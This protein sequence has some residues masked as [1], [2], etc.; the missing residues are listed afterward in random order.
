MCAALA[1]LAVS[2]ATRAQPAP[3][4]A[5][6][7]FV[8]DP[9]Q[10]DEGYFASDMSL[11][12]DGDMA[13]I[14]EIFGDGVDPFNP[15]NKSGTA[16]IFSRPSGPWEEVQTIQHDTPLEGD[17]VGASVDIG[18][19]FAIIAAPGTM[20]LDGRVGAAYIFERDSTC[21]LPS[22]GRSRR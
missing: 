6:P 17:N 13:I 5:A 16:R 18:G 12:G 14:G 20:S 2:S 4:Y 10:V 7:V 9:P 21:P 3:C 1:T 19:S 22:S 11:D 8:G 15:I